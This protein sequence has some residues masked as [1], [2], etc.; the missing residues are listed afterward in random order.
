MLPYLNKCSHKR[1]R[2]VLTLTR[3]KSQRE[4]VYLTG[5]SLIALP[6]LQETRELYAAAANNLLPHDRL[7]LST[8]LTTPDALN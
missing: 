8:T 2:S 1:A 3:H 6:D 5:R 4:V 7:L